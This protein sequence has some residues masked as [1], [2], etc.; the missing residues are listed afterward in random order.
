M[1]TEIVKG[2]NLIQVEILASLVFVF[3]RKYNGAL[4]LYLSH[5]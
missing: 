4:T 3:K 5:P 1:N 2:T